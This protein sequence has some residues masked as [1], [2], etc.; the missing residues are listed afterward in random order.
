MKIGYKEVLTLLNSLVILSKFD[1]TKII[2]YFIKLD[3]IKVFKKFVKKLKS[4]DVN[5]TCEAMINKYLDKHNLDIDL[6]RK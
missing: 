1:L 6:I 2:R 5:K 4:V 3:D